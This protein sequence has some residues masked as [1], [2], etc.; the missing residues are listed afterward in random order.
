MRTWEKKFLIV[1]A[2][3]LAAWRVLEIP[4]VENA[5][6][7]F[8]AAGVVPGTNRVLPPDM[9]ILGLPVLFSLSLILIFGKELK[10]SFYG[11]RL[12]RLH[13]LPRLRVRVLRT[14]L[15]QVSFAVSLP[16]PRQYHWRWTGKLRLWLGTMLAVL[17]RAGVW[18]WQFSQR[19]LHMS[20]VAV[21]R[22]G[23]W[24]W[25][26]LCYIARQAYALCKQ[27]WHWAEPR[28]RQFDH[29]LEVKAHSNPYVADMIS[30][31]S[32][33]ARSIRALLHDRPDQLPRSKHKRLV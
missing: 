23:R 29:W 13:R 7:T 2:V 30:M 33:G 32:E 20:V 11:V 16:R 25:H 26:A 15:P 5:F 22:F 1:L 19:S 14:R 4:H 27:S 18:N 8:L 24:S 31:G 28:L 12:P 9:I 17:H 3:V 6:L 10:A 21:R